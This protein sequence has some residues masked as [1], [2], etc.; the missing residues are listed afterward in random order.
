MTEKFWHKI[1][2]HCPTA[3]DE[4]V[5]SFVTELTGNGVEITDDKTSTDN[6]TVIGY[7][8]ASDSTLTDKLAAIRNYLQ[9]LASQFPEYHE[10]ALK[11]DSIA[12]EDWHRKWKESF[13]PFHLSDTMVIKPSWETYTAAPSERV[14]EI[15]PGMAFG[16]GLHASTRLAMELLEKHLGGLPFPPESTLDVGTGTCILAIGAALLGCENITAID[17]DPE[18]VTAARNNI[19]ANNLSDQI[20]AD[21]TDLDELSGPYD[22]IMANIIHNTLVEMAP[23]LARLLS[24][25]GILIMAGI[26]KGEQA[27]NISDI[28]SNNGLI[29]Q[30]EQSSGEW[31]ALSFRKP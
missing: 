14:I 11:L 28:Y 16:T 25:D 21:S 17:N 30:K 20:E 22:L 8:S 27:E 15:D 10:A 9:E 19:A 12:D 7:L 2:V 24:S 6:S 23:T 1:L 3:I 18:A 5:A 13:K 26:L 31:S 4:T 29:R